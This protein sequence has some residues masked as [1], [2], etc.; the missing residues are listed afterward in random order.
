MIKL[1][2]YFWILTGII[3]VDLI[4]TT[5]G[6]YTGMLVEKYFL[7]RWTVD[8]GLWFFVI[9]KL[10]VSYLGLS[11]LELAW[12]RDL[13]SDRAYSYVIVAYVVIWVVGVIYYQVK[14]MLL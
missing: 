1:S 2:K 6:I 4:T 13:F 14:G 12:Q 9:Y 8:I 7:I 3:F 5:W 11:I 10:S